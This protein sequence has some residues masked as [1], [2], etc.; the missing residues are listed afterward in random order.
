MDKLSEE[1][2]AV[3]AVVPEGPTLRVLLQEKP[4]DM[5]IRQLKDSGLMNGDPRV[6]EIPLQAPAEVLET[7]DCPRTVWF[8]VPWNGWIIDIPFIKGP[9]RE[10]HDGVLMR[11]RKRPCAHVETLMGFRESDDGGLLACWSQ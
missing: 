7:G 2:R 4:S 3:F 8:H 11:G 5:R 1:L 10:R 6:I 9:P